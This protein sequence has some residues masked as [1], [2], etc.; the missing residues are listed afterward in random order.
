MVDRVAVLVDGDN[1][2]PV[3]AKRILERG[4]ALGRV[5]VARVYAD[6]NRGS[7][8]LTAPGYRL[9]HAGTGKNAS[10]LLLAIDALEMALVSGI[11]RY[12]IASS[13][14]DFSHLAHRLRERGLHVVGL[15]ESKAPRSFRAAC[16]AFDLLPVN[17]V[18]A[19][20]PKSVDPAAV[21]S[22]LDRK[23]RS[24]IAMHSEKG[25]GIPL[26]L[27]AQGLQKSHGIGLASTG[28]SSWRGYLSKRPALYD[29]D[30]KGPDAKVRFRPTGFSQAA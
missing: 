16:S 4:Q 23:I 29:L 17:A 2:G 26:Q 15:G 3:H 27:L 18:V 1:V 28:E 30:A 11:G 19:L 12:V 25:G 10:D 20:V 8:W 14:G 24:I 6:A 22:D 13:D 7:D 9:M 21:C 5:D